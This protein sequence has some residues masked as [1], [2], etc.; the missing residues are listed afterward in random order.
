MMK[1]LTFSLTLWL[2]AY[3]GWA[4][5]GYKTLPLNDL[6]AFKAQAGNWMIVGDVT[7]DRNLSIHHEAPP[8]ETGKKKKKS[9]AAP[10]PEHPV[11]YTS[12]Q[13]ILLNF[14]DDQK[15]DNL[16][17][18]WTHGDI[19]LE[20][21]V[22]IP[23]GSNSGI[24][25]QGNY[26]VQLLD[27]WGVKN[28][29]FGDIGG[30]YRN[31]ENEPAKAY[32]GKAPRVN[33]AKAPGLWQ[34]IKISFQAPRFNS[35]GEKVE[36]AR[37]VFVE[38]NGVRIHDNLE[39]PRLTG[40][41][42][43]D[44]EVAEGP[45]M[46]QGDHGPVAFRNIRYR[47]LK[48]ANVSLTGINY[49][50]FDGHFESEKDFK[51]LKPTSIGSTEQLTWE[52]AKKDN[53]FAVK[54]YGALEIPADD[55]YTFS[56]NTGNAMKLVIDGQTISNY[57][58][59]GGKP[60]K[61]TK[62]THSAEITYF[63][64]VS[65][66]SP[67]MGLWV[68]SSNS[69]PQALHAFSSFPPASNV[70]SPIIVETGNS[71]RLLR[72]FLDFKRDRSQRLTHTIAVGNPAG[73]NYIYDMKSGS[74]VCLWRGGFID[75]TPMW[76]DRGDGSFWPIGVVEYLTSK[77]TLVLP[78]QSS[79][80]LELNNIP[81]F[82]SSG[83]TLDGDGLPTFL[84][85]Y[86]GASVKDKS[87]LVEEGKVLQR[88]ISVENAPTGSQVRIA[89]GSQIRKLDNGAYAIDGFDYYIEL[90]SAQEA[91]IADKGATKELLVPATGSVVYQIVW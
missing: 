67:N 28:P 4:Q 1:R 23:K 24:Y 61:L 21:E 19:E 62:G 90:K 27:S 82:R 70:A 35:A 73:L 9:K 38:L 37:F 72:A 45:L 46:I 63:K 89:E 13:G 43:N 69:Y 17:T 54:Y 81:D 59:R 41:P 40:G 16:V 50:V 60:V 6:S 58:E 71:P 64:Y 84:Y 56:A 7:M 68:E 91:T 85:T 2:A 5:E 88:E 66:A 86:S 30:I 33:A 57:Y 18:N 52:V 11:K 48:P 32:A 26:E 47:L 29:G 25:L 55:T 22:M 42:I 77:P 65:W 83:Y 15:K 3:A 51:D 87:K 76:H 14:N 10:E 12:G 36:N 75:A 20:L 31:W 74:V 39:V 78:G 79:A 80:N 8:V 44:K 34:T 53:E 49:E